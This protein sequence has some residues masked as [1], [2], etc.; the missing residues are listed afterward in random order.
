MK[1][2][3]LS[4]LIAAIGG[5]LPVI[6]GAAELDKE[7]LDALPEEEQAMK[8]QVDH[9][10]L[11]FSD[12]LRRFINGRNRLKTQ[13]G[14]KTPQNFLVGL[15]H[16]LEKV[17]LN[18]YWFKGEYANEIRLAAAKNE[19][20]NFQVAVL[21]EIGKAL[22]D[23]SLS[24]GPL[25]STAG[26]GAIPAEN[27]HIYRVGYVKTNPSRYPV[28]YTG[29]WPDILLPNDSIE[30]S[31]TDLGLF[32]VE[33]KVPKDAPSGD[34]EGALSL[35]A[36]CESLAINLK[37]HVY[38]FALP[39]RVPF[40]V[41][42]WTSPVF[43]WGD[44]MSPEEYRALAGEFLEHGIDPICVGRDFYLSEESDFQIHDENLEYCFAR[45]L[46]L[47]SIPQWGNSPERLKTYVDHIRQKGWSDK[48]LIYIGPDEPTEEMFRN[49][50]MPL[51]QKFHS[52]YPD[53]KVF[54]ASECHPDI[55]KGCDIWMTDVSTGKGPQFATENKGE[56]TLWFYFC[57]LPIRVDLCRPL[58]HAP[59][60]EIDNEAIE[61][62]L[63]L[64]LCWKYRVEGMFIWA[65]NQEWK[66]PDLDRRDWEQK[67]WELPAE[68]YPFPYGGTHN[69]NGY[70]IY[71][72]PNPSIRMK[73][74]RDG[75][76][77][78]GYLSILEELGQNHPNRAFRKDAERLTSIPTTVLVDPHYFNKNPRALLEVRNHM[79]NL[80]EKGMTTK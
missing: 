14:E 77:D 5:W 55:D 22:H 2:L 73:I 40:P 65:G 26:K 16:G 75:L 68:P 45:G 20:E 21:P 19:Y 31:G 29:M 18:K 64:W 38:D 80:I 54:L 58:V 59:N 60:L 34:Y 8:N 43:P 39:D 66:A 23:V 62:R 50:N 13:L 30:L 56:S 78:L 70:L 11:P 41:V 36:D 42:A 51:Y 37:L 67:G 76:E 17:P 47:F 7:F 74:V 24:A 28:L 57:H 10:G 9:W 12:Q 4:F 3:M 53:I 33:I 35:E 15:Q 48:A 71:P 1:K 32:W 79:A 44:R 52:L 69:G 46:Q 63:A 49:Q 6:G 72:G 25:D 27:I 61:H